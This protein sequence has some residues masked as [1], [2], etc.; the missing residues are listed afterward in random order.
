VR[1]PITHATRDAPE[2]ARTRNTHKGPPI[3]LGEAATDRFRAN[4][5]TL[6]ADPEPRI[7]PVL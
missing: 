7:L 6:S 5:G 2:R 4:C 3:S 1:H